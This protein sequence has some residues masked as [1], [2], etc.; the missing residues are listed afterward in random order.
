MTNRTPV[1]GSSRQCHGRRA[2]EPA[3]ALAS[4]VR[5]AV[6]VPLA[7]ETAAGE[8]EQRAF[9]LELKHPKRTVRSTPWEGARL[10]V[11]FADWP[12]VTV[13]EPGA[14]VNEKS[15]AC[16][17]VPE[18]ARKNPRPAAPKVSCPG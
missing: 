4:T 17:V 9:E 2:G 3:P 8:I 18:S 12:L 10:R 14:A 7:I 16:G 15:V 11:K 6:A 5:V 1:R 13:A